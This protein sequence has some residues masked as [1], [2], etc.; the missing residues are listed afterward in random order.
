[1][2]GVEVTEDLTRLERR[3]EVILLTTDV[4]LEP[5]G[6][7]AGAFAVVP[8]GDSETLETALGA[9]GE[10][11]GGGE[12]RKG[13][14]R[15]SGL[16]RREH[17]DWS[18][19]FSERRSGD[20]RRQGAA[21]HVGSTASPARTVLAAA[22][23]PGEHEHHHE[24][25]DREQRQARSPAFGGRGHLDLVRS[26]R[27]PAAADASRATG[28]TALTS[29]SV[30]RLG[31]GGL[32]VV[33][34]ARRSA[35][36]RRQRAAGGD[37]NVAGRTASG[38]PSGTGEAGS[39]GAGRRMAASR[40]S[41]SA[42]ASGAPERVPRPWIGSDWADGLGDG[43]PQVHGRQHLTRILLDE[44]VVPVLRVTGATEA[45]HGEARDRRARRCGVARCARRCA[46][47]AARRRR[48]R[49][50]VR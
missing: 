32:G 44:L 6:L 27:G 47:P 15:R 2:S 5:L 43:G 49:R 28:S 4:S 31:V 50:P 33:E 8:R 30:S 11:L 41:N 22:A 9:L 42:A 12:R 25:G 45:V 21:A 26:R 24:Q 36:G 20:D 10:W 40:A 38:P 29:G 1:M 23:D 46:A 17:Q 16:D 3:V 37:A 19:V 7:A 34:R 35:P 14:D 39:R 13:G 48:P 18:K